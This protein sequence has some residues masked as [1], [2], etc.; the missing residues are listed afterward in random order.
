MIP[1]AR[2][3]KARTEPEPVDVRLSLR[4]RFGPGEDETVTVMEDQRVPL[5]GGVLRYRDRIVR[6][7]ARGLVKAALTQPRVWRELMP[8]FRRDRADES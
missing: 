8:L 4:Y 3:G 1:K 2:R 7:F 5:V 6:G